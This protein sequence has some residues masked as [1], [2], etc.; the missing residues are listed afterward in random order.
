MQTIRDILQKAGDSLTA[1]STSARLD[2]QVLLSHVLGVE[3]V[4][5]YTYPEKPIEPEQL[6]EFEQLVARRATGE[7]IAYILGQVGFYDREFI[8]TPDVL[9]PR[10]ETEH[11]VEAAIQHANDTTR[12]IVAADIGTG[13]GAIAITFKAHVP[14]ATVYAVDISPAALDVARRNSEL[15]KTDVNF[16]QGN[17]LDPLIEQG[18]QVDILMANLPYIDSDEVRTLEVSKHEP[19]TAL[20]G[21]R[22]GLAFITELLSKVRQ[23][24]GEDSLILLEIGANQGMLVLSLVSSILSPRAVRLSKDYADLDR[25]IRIEL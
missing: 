10:P 13:S 22:D 1:V 6:T 3:V 7:P 21:G 25:I 15:N 24:C 9:I 4:Y 20:D 8:V 5:L 2:A 19:M 12:A 23:V 14:R 18:V 16:L 11:L 17:L